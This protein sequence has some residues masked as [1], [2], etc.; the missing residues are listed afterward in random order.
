[1]PRYG[2]V[3]LVVTCGIGATALLF[4][5]SREGEQRRVEG[6]F[7]NAAQNHAAALQRSIELE[8]LLIES[9]RSWYMSA[10]RVS[11]D[12]F[13][14]FVAPILQR[15]KGVRALEWVPRVTDAGR[16]EYEAAMRRA[17]APGYRITERAGTGRMI[18][19]APRED[20]FP[21]SDVGPDREADPSLGFDLA[22]EPTRREAIVRC[23]DTG[24]LVATAPV[25][26]VRE[27][28]G[29]HG[30]LVFIPVYE[31]GKP[32]ESLEDRRRHHRGL[33][34]GVFRL[35][36]LVEGALSYLQ[37]MAIDVS[38]S[39]DTA[40][41][42][43]QELFTR[44]APRPGVSPG[45]VRSGPPAGELE[46]QVTLDVAG[47]S[48]SVRCLTAPGF[49]AHRRTSYPTVVLLAG[50]LVTGLLAAYLVA[51]IRRTEELRR[52]QAFLD[53]I[54][55]GL[56]HPIWVLDVYPDGELKI[57]GAN[58][59]WE[60]LSG[61]SS[62]DIL[63]LG[64]DAMRSAFGED[65]FSRSF[66]ALKRCLDSG[67][68]IDDESDRLI[69]GARGWFLRH[70]SPLRDSAGRIWRIIGTT[71]DI[72][73]QKEA[74]HTLVRG[75][76]LF[77]EAERIA[78]LGAW[79]VDLRAGG[80]RCSPEAWSVV[81][82]PASRSTLE[83]LTFQEIAAASHPEDIEPLLERTRRFLSGQPLE[84]FEH[85]FSWGGGPDRTVVV[86]AELER[87]AE[88]QPV[89]AIGTV[90][91]VT[92]RARLQAEVEQAAAE[93]QRTFDAVEPALLVFDSEARLVRLNRPATVLVGASAAYEE[94]LGRHVASLGAGE[95][96]STAARLLASAVLSR[97]TAAE[98]ARDA[99]LG[100]AWALTV[101]IAPVGA[102][103]AERLILVVADITRLVE[104]QESLRRT[105]TMAAMGT[106]VAG[107]AHEVRN[108]LFAITAMLDTLEVEFGQ[109]PTYAQYAEALRSQVNR[110]NLL[111]RDLLEYGKPPALRLREARPDRMVRLAVRACSLLARE[112]GIRLVE[113][114]GPDLPSLD[115][116]A[117]RMHQV[118]ENLV[119][120]AIQHSPRDATVRVAA[121]LFSTGQTGAMRFVV[122]DEGPGIPEAQLTRLFEPFFT[123]REGGT[124]LGLSIVQRIVEAHG[125]RVS[126]E[127]RSP[128]AA[129]AVILPL[130][131][132]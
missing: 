41:P 7:E 31:R 123:R 6:D 42:G 119:A 2:I 37:P 118:L 5:R 110:L 66:A 111:T 76:R 112:R 129:F 45:T 18:P 82:A 15:R 90:Q 30:F 103:V 102:G 68:P 87:D 60:R 38:I 88:G 36:D 26:L 107:V 99:A 29:E 93:W 95:P 11:P 61:R 56:P 33:I 3:A 130:R 132:A 46:H 67:E 91:D 13:S 131:E 121:G 92:D 4:T 14:A 116:D 125:G 109:E 24:R 25:T 114:V 85:R 101:S 71:I 75:Q 89:R 74:E 86:K 43:Q 55:T 28:E 73:R 77:A 128:G 64:L 19:A 69:T 59:A 12:E 122:E 1:V 17:G 104:L 54:Y 10:D 108:P 81:G 49:V 44:R 40:P 124:G 39:D 106:L 117:D 65:G 115:V 84:E 8:L 16:G 48:W 47:R 53:S 78:R 51:S 127:N 32:V 113:D 126:I 79:E 57:V 70:L 105:E 83:E 72:S 63:G 97:T 9:L 52:S 98:E 35:P 94:V 20:Y 50:L 58:P 62:K 80:I 27:T 34:M 120:N 100:K 96:W 22:S 23:R 21:V